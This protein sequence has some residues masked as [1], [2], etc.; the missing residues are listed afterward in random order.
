MTIDN[1]EFR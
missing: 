1:E